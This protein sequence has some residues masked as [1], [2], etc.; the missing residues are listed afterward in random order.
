M[1][2]GFKKWS[3]TN[4]KKSWN[5][6]LSLFIFKDVLGVKIINSFNIILQIKNFILFK[7]QTS[8]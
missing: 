3:K 1:K 4:I 6:I 7:K 5:Y 8:Y 2:V